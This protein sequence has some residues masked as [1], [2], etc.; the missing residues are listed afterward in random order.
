[1]S[2]LILD[3]RGRL[4]EPPAFLAP[5]GERER[6]LGRLLLFIVGGG[7][8]ALVASIVAMMVV[9]GVAAS[10][11]DRPMGPLLK[12][13]V[14]GG[15]AERSLI[16]Y[17]L[18]FAAIGVSLFVMA[19]TLI[20]FAAWLYR[21]PVRSFITAAPRFRWRL[22]AAGFAVGAPLV[23][24]AILLELAWGLTPLEPPIL[25]A[26][27][28]AEAAGYIAVAAVFLFVAALAEE[29][30]F[31][32]WMLQQTSAFTRNIV[33]LLVV[34]GALFS[35]VHGDPDPG[36]FVVRAAMGVGWCWIGLRLGGL[37]FAKIGR[38]HV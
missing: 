29:M 8:I 33:V 1:M 36:A 27:S 31:R 14:E 15:A 12:E 38:A 28:L 6:S 21:R 19:V 10:L 35:L 30:V 2:D 17:S 23:V 16:S 37:E 3:R 25:K 32:G 13:L 7:L 26:V 20:A 5:V 4:L 9:G 18:E 24:I 22:V 34:N 11:T